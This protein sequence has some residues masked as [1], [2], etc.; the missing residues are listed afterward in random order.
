LVSE[1]GEVS[2]SDDLVDVPLIVGVL[3]VL[4]GEHGA[5]P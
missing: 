1:R 4:H 3:A 5:A 2:A